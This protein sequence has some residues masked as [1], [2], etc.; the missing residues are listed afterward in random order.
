VIDVTSTPDSTKTAQ[1]FLDKWKAADY[2]GMYA[3]LTPTSRDAISQD[4]FVKLYTETAENL[5]LKDMETS[6][7]SSLTNTQI[8]QAGVCCHLS[9][10]PGGGPAAPDGDEPADD[11]MARGKR[12]CVGTD[13]MIML[14]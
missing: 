1:E 11:Q 12:A 13:G 6:I 8:C 5:T 3:M 9:Y 2:A 14:R 7:L 4:Q 10:Q